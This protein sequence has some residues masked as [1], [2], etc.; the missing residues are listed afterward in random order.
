MLYSSFH[1]R[2]CGIHTVY[3]YTAWDLGGNEWMF[4]LTLALFSSYLHHLTIHGAGVRGGGVT[5]LICRVIL[6]Q[7]LLR[8]IADK[9]KDG[10]SRFSTS[11]LIKDSR[12]IH[13]F[14]HILYCIDDKQFQVT[15]IIDILRDTSFTFL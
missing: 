10:P 12:F 8:F 4:L 3:R 13:S 11:F 14:I 2:S 15:N 7:F 5:R 6:Q 1:A 9:K